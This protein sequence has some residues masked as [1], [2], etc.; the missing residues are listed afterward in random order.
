ML[1]EYERNSQ[2]IA[3]RLP[4]TVSDAIEVDVHRSF[5]N[6]REMLPASTL[7]RILKAYAITN[8]ALDYC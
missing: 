2:L 4:K 6:L 5:S 3:Q 8:P 1:Q 7:N